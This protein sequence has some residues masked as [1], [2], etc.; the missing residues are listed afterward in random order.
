[1]ARAGP[2]D[3]HLRFA[4]SGLPP[5]ARRSSRDRPWDGPMEFILNGR[6]VAVDA[7]PGESLLAVLR[8]RC[9]LRSMKDGCAPEGSCGACTVIVD[10]RPVV[11]CAQSAARLAGRRIETLEG[12]PAE[13]RTAW[14]D[15]LAA[16]GG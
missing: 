10:G 16:T 2:P 5:R 11:S 3:R 4:F 1:M 12:L 13:S 9:G 7:A 8:E 15:A 6:R 14:A